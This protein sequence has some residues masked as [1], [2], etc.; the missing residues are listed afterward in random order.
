MSVDRIAA[1]GRPAAYS[2]RFGSAQ[3]SLRSPNTAIP[4]RSF[5]MARQTIVTLVDDLDGSEARETVDFAL[6]G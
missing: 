1:R 2:C 6:D 4:A 5:R 3:R